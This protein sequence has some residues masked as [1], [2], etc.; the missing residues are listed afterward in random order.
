MPDASSKSGEF[1]GRQIPFALPERF[2]LWLLALFAL[3]RPAQAQAV[4][5]PNGSVTGTL[6]ATRTALTY[7]YTVTQDEDATFTLKT[8]TNLSA[9]VR[10]YDSDG[11]SQL[12]S[13]YAGAGGGGTGVM[14]VPHLAPGA[15][16]HVSVTLNSG[17]DTF[18]LSNTVTPPALAN[19][20]EP[21]DDYTHARAYAVNATTTGHLGYSRTAY[22]TVDG[23][24]WYAI[25]IP[26]DGDVTFTIATDPT[27][28]AYVRFYDSNGTSQLS[29]A[30]A[31]AGGGGFG[32]TTVPHLAP[33]ATYYVAVTLG[34][35]YGGY[36]LSNVNAA[37]TVVNDNEVNDTPAQAAHLPGLVGFTGRLGYSRTAYS[38]VDGADWYTVTIPQ[39]GNATFTLS[40]GSTLSAYIRFYDV[41]GMT[42]VGYAYAGAGGGGTGVLT[43]PHLAPGAT[44]YVAVTLSGG[45]GGYSV[46]ASLAPVVDAINPIPGTTK[47]NAVPFAP[48][49]SVTGN[50][51]YSQNSYY[52]VS[53]A[54]WYS[55]IAPID[56][57][58]T[59][60]L[61]TD[62]L[63][64]LSAYV[65]FYDVGGSSQI[66]YAYTGS[67]SV[68]SVIVPH[69][70]PGA[71]Y[72]VEVT[73]NGGYGG[74]TLSNTVAPLFV[75]NDAEPND[76]YDAGHSAEQPVQYHRASRLFPNVLW[77]SGRSGL[78]QNHAARRAFSGQYL[79]V[80]AAVGLPAPV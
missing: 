76:T 4:L 65:R 57:D 36:T 79:A 64:P 18:T 26:K 46:A 37:Q 10:F 52:T 34:G 59:F 29:Y 69:L 3:A 73:L 45:Y 27:L 78:L 25:T 55:F 31:G 9:F 54:A 80:R 77:R 62:T 6:D 12:Y 71:T 60:T 35:G 51:G 50:L 11:T 49:S 47:A 1:H 24:D 72:Y 23:A 68:S 41:D 20:A 75:A 43:V 13:A 5:N 39:N 48:D 53:G 44:Y 19:D 61:A 22:N 67:N 42:Q 33:G 21:N 30:Y 38:D 16:Y 63:L 70:A 17:A 40:T 58:V 7:S 66:A 2:A 56:S 32:A 74:Y 8:G 15:T 14:T 28:S